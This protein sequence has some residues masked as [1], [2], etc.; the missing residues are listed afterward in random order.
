MKLAKGMYPCQDVPVVIFDQGCSK[1]CLYCGLSNRFFLEETIIATGLENILA[2]VTNFKGV[3]LSPASDCFLRQNAELTH[4][5]LEE[6]WKRKELFT[7]LVITKQIIPAKTIELFAKNKHR[8]VLQVSVPSINEEVISILEPGSALISERLKMI[9]GLT[10]ADFSVIAVAMPWFNLDNDIN[11]LPKALAEVGVL[12]VIVATGVLT[13]R[14]KQ[15]MINSGNNQI[16]NAALLIRS[17]TS[18]GYVL[19][20]EEKVLMLK[21][22]TEAFS[23]AKIKS[24][25]CTSDNHD[26]NGNELPLCTK[27]KHHNF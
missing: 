4:S 26:L 15:R 11:S 14:Q 2:E 19:P 3:Y 8:L 9:K 6:V 13:H 22:I 12:R 1:P 17:S 10:E 27:F 18:N 21:K 7:P 16:E 20:I 5:L 24:V 23:K 25:V